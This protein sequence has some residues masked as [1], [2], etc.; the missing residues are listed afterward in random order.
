MTERKLLNM[1][2]VFHD[3]SK[4]MKSPAEVNSN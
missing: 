4:G 1:T 2:T 3:I